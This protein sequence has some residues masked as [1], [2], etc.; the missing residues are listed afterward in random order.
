MSKVYE[1][2]VSN[3]LAILNDSREFFTSG[4][5]LS[6]DEQRCELSMRLK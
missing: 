6:G 5:V 1:L 4:K 3:D 2:E